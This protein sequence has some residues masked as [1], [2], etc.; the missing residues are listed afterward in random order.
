MKP[1]KKQV[2]IISGAAVFTAAAGVAT[3]VV[4]KKVRRSR[5]PTPKPNQELPSWIDPA[6][7]YQRQ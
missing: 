7:R 3:V 1:T 6:N 4:A 5:R 2:A